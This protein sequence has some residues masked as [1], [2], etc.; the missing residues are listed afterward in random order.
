MPSCF[1]H[2]ATAFGE[3]R[4]VGAQFGFADGGLPIGLSVVVLSS[5]SGMPH[6]FR[7]QILLPDLMLAEGK[8]GIA[9]FW[10]VSDLE[11][12]IEIS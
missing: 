8:E 10:A 7:K 9:G 2:R 1:S 3:V 4:P 6:P 11:S 12:A 5:F